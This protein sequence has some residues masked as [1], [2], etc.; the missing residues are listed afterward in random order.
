MLEGTEDNVQRTHC[1]GDVDIEKDLIS[2]D[3]SSL[4]LVI[5]ELKEVIEEH[6]EYD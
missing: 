2:V 6:Y 1:L 5:V 3:E 4:D